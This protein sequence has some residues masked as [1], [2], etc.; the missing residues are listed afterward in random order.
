VKGALRMAGT[1]KWTVRLEAIDAD[2]K[3]SE[4]Y[5]LVTIVRDADRRDG[6]D[7]GLKL[8]EGKAVLERLQGRI[9]QDQVDRAVMKHRSCAG[10]G[11][12]R[13]IHDY[14][15]RHV[16]TL[17]GKVAIEAP[18]FRACRCKIGL[19]QGRAGHAVMDLLPGRTTPVGRS[20]KAR[21]GHCR[22]AVGVNHA[23]ELL[24]PSQVSS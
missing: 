13:S 2:G 10:C 16:Q 15:S 24:G 6:A 5:E 19:Q 20:L 7:F 23:T 3:R 12:R 22:A 9:A 21:I 11:A 17:F 8:A 1:V 4:A 14:Q 18:R